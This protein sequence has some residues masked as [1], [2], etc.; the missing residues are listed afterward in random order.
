MKKKI[1]LIMQEVLKKVIVLLCCMSTSFVMPAATTVTFNGTI[2][3][4]W[5]TGGNWSN[6]TGPSQGDVVVIAAGKKAVIGSAVVSELSHIELKAGSDLKN[7]GTLNLL[8]TFAKPGLWFENAKFRNDGVLSINMLASPNQYHCIEFKGTAGGKDT[9]ILNGSNTF[10]NTVVSGTRYV[11]YSNMG[12]Q[13][14][15]GG[16]GFTL[17][18]SGSGVNFGLLKF[19]GGE[20]SVT[21]ESGF[22]VQQYTRFTDGAN[23]PDIYFEA[24]NV[25][26]NN[27][28]NVTITPASMQGANA[29]VVMDINPANRHAINFNNYGT[30]SSTNNGKGIQMGC[31][32]ATGDPSNINLTNAGTIN[33][34]IPSASEAFNVRNATHVN[35]TNSGT[36]NLKAAEHAIKLT[37]TLQLVQQLINTGTVNIT[38]GKIQGI[39]TSPAIKPN[40]LNNTGGMI[41]FVYDNPDGTTVA[42]SDSVLVINNGGVITGSCTF[43]AGTLNTSNGTLLPGDNGTGIGKMILTPVNGLF[44]LSGSL[45]ADVN[46]KTTPG[47]DFDQLL[48]SEACTLNLTGAETF[49]VNTG[50]SY[51][52]VSVHWRKTRHSIETLT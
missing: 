50:G 15:I 10:I 27:Y 52:P 28:G 24:N 40:I 18:S 45:T 16:T 41:N 13:V 3:T 23:Y 6:G 44:T 30:F 39:T 22:T 46:G 5:S 31:K 25:T 11:F 7:N 48:F 51:A 36:L 43:G 35:I 21:F 32:S 19:I 4:D 33:L 9:L 1:I 17:G 34:M 2:N 37:A 14:S 29:C 49:S 47:T 26:F 12:K 20:S 42:T 8:P 38:S